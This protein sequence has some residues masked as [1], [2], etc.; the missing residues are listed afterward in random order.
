MQ[1]QGAPVFF[2]LR[3]ILAGPREPGRDPCGEVRLNLA[4]RQVSGPS[5]LEP[6]ASPL[7]SGAAS[8]SAGRS[9]AQSSVRT[10]TNAAAAANELQMRL[11]RCGCFAKIRTEFVSPVVV[12]QGERGMAETLAFPPTT[13]SS[14]LSAAFSGLG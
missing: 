4:P 1:A 5:A 3:V 11:A 14:R 10:V 7:V 2:V 8:A 9:R 13:L 6:G 12:Q